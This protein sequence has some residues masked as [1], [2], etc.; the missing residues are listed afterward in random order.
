MFTTF[1]KYL[2]ANP[3]Q[4][5]AYKGVYNIEVGLGDK[6]EGWEIDL[7]KATAVIRKKKNLN[8]K[9]LVEVEDESLYALYKGKLL[10]DELEI[11]GRIKLTGSAAIKSKFLNLITAFLE[12]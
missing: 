7:S 9:L 5:K 1:K 3:K 11:Q 4:V 12:R 8:P 10:L 6:T 2:K